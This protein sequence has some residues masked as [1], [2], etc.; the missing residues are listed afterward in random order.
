MNRPMS[1]CWL[2][3]AFAV[4]CL[5]ST[6]FANSVSM[7]LTSAGSTALGGVYVGPYTASVNGVSTS[8]IC[9][10]FLDDSFVGESWQA[11]VNSF[12]S[13]SFTKWASYFPST[14]VSLYEQAA[15]LSMQMMSPTNASQIG[16]IQYAVWAVFDPAA[17]NNLSGTDLANAQAWLASAAAQTYTTSQFSNLIIYTAIP[18]TAKCPGFTCPPNSPQEFFAFAVPEGGSLLAYLLLAGAASFGGMFYQKRFGV[19]SSTT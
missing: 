5:T 17:L 11:N 16:D 15:W 4:L 10:D 7:T 13:L 1:K 14:Y 9:D 6:A 12:S 3:T 2:L 19:R 8:V 18:G